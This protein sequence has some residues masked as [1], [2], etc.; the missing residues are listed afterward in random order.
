MSVRVIGVDAD[1]H[2]LEIARERLARYGDRVQ[3]YNS[4]FNTFFKTYP[5][6]LERPNKILFD[7][8]ISS[9]HYEKGLRGFSFAKEELLDM[10]LDKDLETS[11]FHIVNNYP[12]KELADIIYTYGEERYS[13]KIASAIITERQK[14]Q[15]RT[16]V[17][18][19]D[20][21]ESAVPPEYRRKKIHSATRTFQALRIA[22]NG[23]LARLSSALDDAFSLLMPE[24]RIGVISFHS[25]EDRIVKNFF[26]D[27]SR[28]CS[29]PPEWPQC[30][31]DRKPK[32][33]LLTKKPIEASPEEITANP[34]GR[35]AK[36]RVL[37]KI[38]DEDF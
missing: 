35:S 23:E 36:L 24:G 7:L 30:K 29:C 2:I 8:G 6:E 12:E 16:T 15:I 32:A 20:L 38:A 17:Q 11:A 9:F 31:C 33:Q 3:L 5:A 26:R 14:E 28:I 1:P 22:V 27:K 18:L 4:W 21:I 19:R 37:K 13:R 10:R 25:L 34:R